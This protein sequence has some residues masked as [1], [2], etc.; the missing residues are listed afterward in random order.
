[1]DTLIIFILLGF[2]GLAA[3]HMYEA[4][5]QAA[6][7][8]QGYLASEGMIN[9]PYQDMS[10]YSSTQA[11]VDQLTGELILEPGTVDQMLNQ[12]NP[13]VGTASGTVSIT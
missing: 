4:R 8:D 5:Q 7:P 13:I 1:M 11:T 6:M 9:N 3:Y 12:S 10:L 2:G